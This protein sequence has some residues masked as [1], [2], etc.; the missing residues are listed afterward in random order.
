MAVEYFPSTDKPGFMGENMKQFIH[1]LG[2]RTI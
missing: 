1:K 2:Q